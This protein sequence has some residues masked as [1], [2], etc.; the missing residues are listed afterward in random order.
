M[1]P[2]C[3]QLNKALDTH[4]RGDDQVTDAHCAAALCD[5]KPPNSAEIARFLGPGRRLATSSET[6]GLPGSGR[7]IAGHLVLS[8]RPTLALA[9]LLC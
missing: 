2:V 5:L 3:E 7:S 1:S 9:Q 8:L 4:I 6:P